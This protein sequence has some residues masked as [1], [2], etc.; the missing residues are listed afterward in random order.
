MSHGVGDQGIIIGLD[1]S[2]GMLAVSRKRIRK[3]SLTSRTELVRAEGAHVPFQAGCFDGIFLS[4]TLELFDTPELTKVLHACYRLLHDSGRIVIVALTEAENHNLAL[5]IYHWAH[6]Q[7]PI[8]IDCRPIFV[9]PL[10]SA[11]GFNIKQK[12]TLR[13]WGL[14]VSIVLAGKKLIECASTFDT[15]VIITTSRQHSKTMVA[16]I[17]TCCSLFSG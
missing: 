11:A 7:F 9:D 16:R 13:M 2:A 3:L 17:E 1:L 6:R 12:K 8:V 5:K 10:L 15:I 14:P 4:F